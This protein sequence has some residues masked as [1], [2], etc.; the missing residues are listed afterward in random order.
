MPTSTIN[1]ANRGL[2]LA[3]P[4]DVIPE[5]AYTNLL[6]MTSN[7]DVYIEPRGG[8]DRINGSP[9]PAAVHSQGR[10]E[11]RTAA[12]L[13]QGAS[14][15][16]YRNFSSI[17][18][19][20]SGNPLTFREATPDLSTAPQIAAF[21]SNRRDKDS[22]TAVTAFGIAG[23]MAVATAVAASAQ[24]KTIDLFEYTTNGAI[25]SAWATS[26]ATITTTT[27]DP[28]Q[29]TYAG[30]IA[31]AG[32]STTGTATRTVSLNLNQFTTAGDSDDSDWIKVYLRTDVPTNL[33]E[34][35]I[36]FDIDASTNDFQHNYYWK[37][38]VASTAAGGAA[39]IQTSFQAYQAGAQTEVQTLSDFTDTLGTTL[40]PPQMSLGVSQWTTLFVKKSDFQRVGTANRD[41][42]NVAAI[43]VVVITGTGG[44]VNVGIDGMV[45]QGGTEHKLA[46]EYDWLYRYENGTTGTV[47]PFSAVM[48][49]QVTI[50]KTAAT[51]TVTNPRDTQA[52]FIQ[53]YRRGGDFPE[54][55][56]FVTRQA[57]AAWTGTVTITDGVSDDSLG[58]PADLTQVELSNMDVDTAA[59]PTSIQR[60]LDNGGSYTDYTA[61]APSGT[62]L[63][64]PLSTIAD[65]DWIAIGADL[66]FRKILLVA[67][68]VNTTT[69]TMVVQYWNGVAW[70]AVANLSDGTAVGTVS[71][72]QTGVVSFSF[73][74]DWETVSVNS[75]SAYYIR[76]SSTV[77]VDSPTWLGVRVGATFIDATTC[78][79]HLGRLWVDDTE[80]PDRLWYS[81]NL[82][83][84]QFSES[85]WI[86]ATVQ[87][88]PVVR[89][90]A[91]DE[92]L[93]AFTQQTVKRVIGRD[94]ESFQA[95]PTGA[96]RG[97]FSKAAICKGDTQIFYRS[98]DG[99]YSLS[100]SG[101]ET[102]LSDQIDP[103]FNGPADNTA[104]N[105]YQVD[106]SYAST[107]TMSFFNKKVRFGYT[108]TN[109]T[110]Y[111]LI[112]DTLMKRW[113][114]TDQ[115]VCSY[116][117]IESDGDLYSG[118]SDGYVY[119]REVGFTDEGTAIPFDFTTR[120][121]DF[122]APQADKYLTD[123][124]LDCDLGGAAVT[125]YL[126]FDTGSSQISQAI[127]GTGRQRINI[128][129]PE[130]TLVQNVALRVAGTNNSVRV[131]F[132][133][134]TIDYIQG[135]MA[136]KRFDT[137]E[138]DFGYTRFKFIRRMWISA[139]APG[140]VTMK[141]YVDNSLQHTET[142]SASVQQGW[143]K[144][145][146]KFPPN[147]KGKLFRFVFT[148]E[149]AFRLFLNQSDIEW[150]PLAGE[151]GYQRARIQ[152]VG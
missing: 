89:P 110:R 68:G 135:P 67:G 23:A 46:G 32:A 53:L 95:I 75:I 28:A 51:V 29:G 136:V 109:G 114:P 122:G 34:I 71:M 40:I 37:S 106:G 2:F 80:H 55:W 152:A 47:S 129:V 78:E 58:D 11:N 1:L 19:G 98:Y 92:Q 88:D 147:L 79:N 63:V 97:L 33:T 151:R 64:G 103:L 5:G 77:S 102:K 3:T 35:R 96:N 26:S 66:P 100:A 38:V 125:A 59:L 101:Y 69:T 150:H 99:I 131:R 123:A 43:R 14:T 133:K 112:Y 82:E 50:T 49:D 52:T 27:A 44:A 12:Y 141:V 148:S 65:G 91:L 107:E 13:Y 146:I 90:F 86:P 7:K 149:T 134:F 10:L 132:Y 87:G 138:M 36:L 25:Q 94:A 31:I 120:Y 42:G 4:G 61:Q 127:T 57:V 116:L 85:N 60:T 62:V 72:A 142:F 73:P 130:E 8:T 119:N 108:A 145:E 41:W 93:F 139:N 30:N 140:E 9:L 20:Y 144:V 56:F 126:S 16:L 74:G 143:Q 137:M 84:E 113:E 45:M 21:D 22:G 105:L 124:L 48:S 70:T 24:T 115:P 18:T 39:L 76:M 128:P 54:D 111:E 83:P 81:D 17:E 15:A 104:P 121:M 117:T 6:N 118:N